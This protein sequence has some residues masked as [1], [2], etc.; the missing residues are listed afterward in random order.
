M[1]SAC[2]QFLETTANAENYLHYAFIAEKCGLRSSKDLAQKFL[3]QNCAIM[4]KSKDM[5][6]KN[7]VQIA[8]NLCKNGSKMFENVMKSVESINDE[9]NL[10]LLDTY[11]AI[12]QSFVSVA[13]TFF[14]KKKKT[15]WNQFGNCMD[16]FI[17]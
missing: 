1:K 16:L 12:Y 5:P 15:K 13:W 3:T 6:Q 9:N 8:E 4:C 10:L 17:Y 7:S 2:N 14:E 11:Q